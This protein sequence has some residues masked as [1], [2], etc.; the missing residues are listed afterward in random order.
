[1]YI[2]AYLEI[3]TPYLPKGSNSLHL[4]EKDSSRCEA[5]PKTS[6]RTKVDHSLVGFILPWRSVEV[7]G[8]L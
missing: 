8:T 3:G 7:D 1:M 5:I 6:K 4:D 2:I